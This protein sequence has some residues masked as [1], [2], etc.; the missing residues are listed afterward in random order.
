MQRFKTALKLLPS[1]PHQAKKTVV[2]IIYAT[3][4]KSSSVFGGILGASGHVGLLL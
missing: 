2:S 3:E 1:G 4:D